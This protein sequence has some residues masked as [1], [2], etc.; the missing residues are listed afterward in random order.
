M[1]KYVSFKDEKYYTYMLKLINSIG[2]RKLEYNW[3]ITDIEAYPQDN[4]ELDNL[5]GE[6]DYLFLSI[7]CDIKNK[8]MI[9]IDSFGIIFNTFEF[10]PTFLLQYQNKFNNLT[11]RNDLIG[12]GEKR[13]IKEISILYFSN[14][15]SYIFFI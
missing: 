13:F 12:T 3:L 6:N 10:D 14:F 11:N 15:N 7:D 4:G 2:G 1:K 5:I 8:W 9:E